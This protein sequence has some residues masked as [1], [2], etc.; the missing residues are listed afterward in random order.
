MKG[1][2][3]KENLSLYCQFRKNHQEP[4]VLCGK[5]EADGHHED[6]SKP[7][8]VIWLCQEHHSQLHYIKRKNPCFDINI[9]SNI[10]TFDKE[11]KILNYYDSVV[12][13]FKI[14]SKEEHELWKEARHLALDLNVSMR[15]LIFLALKVFV[16][17]HNAEKE[18]K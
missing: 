8:D 4:C 12:F 9:L 17:K 1:M 11:L 14:I 5:A 3:N 7:V 18:G 6:Y 15:V 13:Q 16:D 2:L 10:E